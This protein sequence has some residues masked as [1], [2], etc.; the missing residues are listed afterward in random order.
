RP[1]GTCASSSRIIKRTA[2]AMADA[3]RVDALVIGSGTGGYPAGVR[4]GQ[5]GVKTIVVE[6]EKPGGVCLNVGCIPSKA[7]IHA[8]K[9]F[10]KAKHLDEIG[11]KLPG[12]PSI[13]WAATQKWKAG[14]VAKLTSGVRQLLKANGCQY[15]EGEAT[16]VGPRQ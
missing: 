4:L 10:D 16:L 3:V 11:I 14:V 5:L 1:R 7:M 13:D 9:T 6:K 8:A 2:M 12:A 15:L